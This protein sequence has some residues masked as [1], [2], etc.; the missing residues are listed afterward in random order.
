MRLE[1]H[2]ERRELEGGVWLLR[3]GGKEYVLLGD[4]PAALHG[5][6]VVVEGELDEG[7][8]LAMAGPQVVVRSV[9]RG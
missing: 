4:V 3:S 1:G 2:L 7:F 9:R 5:A 8:G 6:R